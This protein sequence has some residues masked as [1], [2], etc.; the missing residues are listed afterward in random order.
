MLSALYRHRLWR[1][2]PAIAFK[3]NVGH[4]YDPVAYTGA[5]TNHCPHS[6]ADTLAHR[7]ADAGPP[8]DRVGFRKCRICIC[9][10]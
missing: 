9:D 7:D 6:H 5:G 4:D 8:A 2:Q 10:K 1:L 3:K